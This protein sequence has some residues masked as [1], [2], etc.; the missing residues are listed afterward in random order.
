MEELRQKSFLKVWWHFATLFEIYYFL[1]YNTITHPF[2]LHHSPRPVFLNPHRVFAQQREPPWDA[3]PR[4]ELGPALQQKILICVSRPRRKSKR[5]LVR[6]TYTCRV[7]NSLG[8]LQDSSETWMY[9][10]MSAVK[11]GKY[12]P[13]QSVSVGLL[14]VSVQSKHRNSLFRY[15][16][17]TTETNVLF[18][19]VPKL[20]SVPVSVVSNR[21]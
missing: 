20:F 7:W 10:R 13:Y 17:E 19:I 9:V 5:M 4:F 12:A 14:F 8:C 15:R 1:T 18:R 11:N 2:I 6:R 3:E 21:N 16:S